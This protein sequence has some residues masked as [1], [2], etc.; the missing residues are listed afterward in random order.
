MSELIKK[1]TTP[2]QSAKYISVEKNTPEFYV[3]QKLLK[4]AGNDGNTSV[5]SDRGEPNVF[6]MFL[7]EIKKL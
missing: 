7:E 6:E 5:Y 4:W 3:A 1:L 2:T